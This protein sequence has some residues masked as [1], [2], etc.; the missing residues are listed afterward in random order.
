[1]VQISRRQTEKSKRNWFRRNAVVTPP[2]P[3][4]SPLHPILTPCSNHSTYLLVSPLP[5]S[6]HSHVRDEV[7]NN[8]RHI[9]Y[10]LLVFFTS[11]IS[12]FFAGISS[13]SFSLYLAAV[14]VFLFCLF[15]H[16][17]TFSSSLAVLSFLTIQARHVYLLLTLRRNEFMISFPVV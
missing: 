13:S 2:P 6:R 8:C 5:P 11:G 16:H 15:I 1:M 17:F 4:V 12:Q 3:L 9:L 14:Y 10:T 7:I